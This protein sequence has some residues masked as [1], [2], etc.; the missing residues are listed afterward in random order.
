MVQK[1]FEIGNAIPHFQYLDPSLSGPEFEYYWN[2]R[3]DMTG[4]FTQLNSQYH[5]FVNQNLDSVVSL[6]IVMFVLILVLCFG[7]LALFLWPF[8]RDTANETRRIAELLSQLPAEVDMVRR[9]AG[10]VGLLLHLALGCYTCET[11]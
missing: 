1:Y 9:G 11:W 3:P 8:M 4:G 2:T 7:Y 5:T 10:G 6:H